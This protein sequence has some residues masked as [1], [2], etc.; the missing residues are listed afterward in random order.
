MAHKLIQYFITR[1][2]YGI[3]LLLFIIATITLISL[4][5]PAEEPPTPQHLIQILPT[6]I[7][8]VPHNQAAYWQDEE[9]QTGDNLPL[10]LKRL[11]IN[12]SEIQHLIQ[13]S[14]FDLKQLNLKSGQIISVRLN[15]EHHISDIQFFNDDDNGERNLIAIQKN[16]HKWH[17]HS[18][19]AET[20]TLPTLRSVIITSSATGALARAGVPIEIRMALKEI[21]HQQIDLDQLDTG[22]HIRI[23]YETL[24]FRGQAVA[25]GNILAAEIT[26][27]QQTYSRY[28]F[29]SQHQ[30]GHF[31]DENGQPKNQGFNNQPIEYYSRISSPYGIRIHP[32]LGSVRMHTGIDYAAPTG[33]KILAPSNGIVSFIGWKGG[34]GKT[35]I[36][37]HH[38][39]IETLYA[40]MSAYPAHLTVGQPIKAGE[41][42]G[43]VGSTGRSTG[44][45]LHYE[46]RINGQHINPA[47]IAL[48]TPQLTPQELPLFIQQ[49]NHIQH[50]FALINQLP[51]MVSQQD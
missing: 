2:Y 1:P 39:G 44:P 34:Y 32:I 6:P 15:T 5:Q 26:H 40:H 41:I 9:V 12:Q 33:T 11:G 14:P 29:E 30:I 17:I 23:L 25:T 8:A 51:V 27:R 20:Q 38:H 49:R 21:F 19:T 48:P 50:I 28:Y 42:I 13:E 24:Y 47:S 36:L 46:V 31:Y 16:N 4:Q 43:F 37:S 10:L 3:I 45:H 7:L 18:A 22:D 35:V